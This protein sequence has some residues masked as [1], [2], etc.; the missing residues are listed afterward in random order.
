MAP[1]LS[2]IFIKEPKL[3]FGNQNEC[4]ESKGGLYLFGPYGKYSSGEAT[5]IVADVGIIGTSKSISD[6]TNFFAFIRKPIHANS[7]GGIHFPGLG[8]EGKLHFDVQFD[9]QW[10][11]PITAADIRECSELD[12]R[13]DRIDF[14]LDLLEKK[15]KSIH[16]KH[17]ATLVICALPIEM[18]RLLK[19]PEQEGYR[20]TIT[21]RRFEKKGITSQQLKGDYDLHNIIKV[22]GLKYEMPTQLMLPHTL[23]VA[24]TKG[25]QDLATRAWNVTM[26][27]YY[28]SKGIP[29]KIAQ[30][31]TGTCYAGISFYRELD[32]D[33]TPSMKASITHLFLHTGECLVL[34]GEPF[35]WE[36]SRTSPRLTEAQAKKIRDQIV[37]AFK[38]THN[39]E[40]A[41]LVI[42]KKTLFTDEE[43]RGF[44]QGKDDT[45]KQTDLLTIQ[46]S[47]IDWYRKG[48]WPI[49][50]NTV[51]KAPG[52]EYFIFTLGFIQEMHTFPKPGIPIPIRVQPSNLDSTETKMCQEILSLSKLNWNNTDFSDQF[53][54]TLSVSDAISE[55][56]S[57]ARARSIIP[58]DQYKYYM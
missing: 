36:E 18:I 4:E 22:F 1:Q 33:G 41:R 21:H 46:S 15:I 53:P 23:D 24:K 19:S 11:E 39:Q 31:E 29:W 17:T 2:T 45:V 54:V 48:K 28:K 51:I 58:S 47:S 16:S 49:V 26:A 9:E 10:Q 57:E 34:T 20:I 44:L 42:H 8:I 7:V 25:V 6:T 13:E 3:I 40:P 30:L 50:R 37:T 56:L 55:I 32:K 38:N 12:L 5:P 43:K 35:K 52:P 14:F 27:L